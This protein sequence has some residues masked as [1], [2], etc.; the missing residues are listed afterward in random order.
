MNAT[1][2]LSPLEIRAATLYANRFAEGGWMT[3]AQERENLKDCLE[4]WPFLKPSIQA[5]YLKLAEEN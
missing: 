1:Q 3:P 2:P 4:D 5:K